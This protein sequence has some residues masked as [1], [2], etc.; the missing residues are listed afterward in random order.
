M[1]KGLRVLIVEDSEDD[2][3]LL[4]RALRR[5]GYDLMFERVDTAEAMKAVLAQRTW[6]IIISD[7]AM[8]NFSALTALA[9]MKERGLDLPFIL[10]SGA[11]GEEVAVEAMKASAHDYIMKGNL[12]RL[13]PAIERELREADVRREHRRAEEQI[14]QTNIELQTAIENL[15]ASQAQLLQSEKLA[16]IGELVSGTAHEIRNPLTAIS[17]Y[18]EML[19]KEVESEKAEEYIEILN[20]QTERVIAIVNNLL[21]FARKGE[22][23]RSYFSINEGVVSTVDLLTYKLRVNNIETIFELDPALPEIMADYNQIQQVFL[24]IVTNAEQSMMAANGKG[25]L[26]I[27]TKKVGEMIRITFA[28]DGPGIPASKL[29][30][31]FEPFFTTKGVG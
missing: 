19:P 1:G 31:I 8:P 23:K 26:T 11:I 15:R 13:I 16:A 14:I 20:V 3:L 28:D 29:D 30:R 6:D 9:L 12:A 21:A 27:A 22:A 10:L 5:D 24:N 18:L 2:A 4:I 25:T 7:Y 17:M